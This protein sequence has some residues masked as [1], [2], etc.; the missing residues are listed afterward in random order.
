MDGPINLQGHDAL[1]DGFADDDDTP[2]PPPISSVGG[3]KRGGKKKKVCVVSQGPV[4]FAF[5]LCLLPRIVTA[6]GAASINWWSLTST[7][8]GFGGG[9]LI[10]SC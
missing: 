3:K 9:F 8:Q 7:L 4:F 2:T 1:C 5:C 10:R 6:I